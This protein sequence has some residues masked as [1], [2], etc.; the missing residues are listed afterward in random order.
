MVT[1][2]K[3]TRS[4]FVRLIQF[5]DCVLK[6][7]MAMEWHELFLIF[8][9]KVNFFAVRTFCNGSNGQKLY[10]KYKYQKML[11]SFHCHVCFQNTV[12]KLYQ[13]DKT[14]S[15]Y[16][17]NGNHTIKTPFVTVLT[18][19]LLLVGDFYLLTVCLESAMFFLPEN[20]KYHKGGFVFHGVKLFIMRLTK[21]RFCSFAMV[22]GPVKG[23]L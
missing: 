10:F 17:E 1:V 19:I 2:F 22:E 23:F 13:S 20:T 6:T 7:Y 12:Q 5:L 14:W 4:G 21:T 16:R 18:R 3:I 9:L 8:W 15:S 11:L